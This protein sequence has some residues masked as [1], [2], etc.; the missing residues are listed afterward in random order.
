MAAHAVYPLTRSTTSAVR[1]IV[2]AAGH[3]YGWPV[4]QG[5]SQSISDALASILTAHGGAIE[6]G[7]RVKR[8]ADLPRTD[9]VMLALAPTAVADI[10]GDALPPRVSRAYRRWRY[11]P[12]VFKL[13]LAVEGGLPWTNEY[14]RRAGVVHVGG[15]LEEV[16]AIEREVNRGVMPERPFVLVGQQYLAD[17]TRSSGNIH[18]VWTYA[19]VPNGYP[20]D[21]EEA[22]L[23]QLERFAPGTRERIVGKF[24]RGTSALAAYNTN[25]VGGDILTGANNPRQVLAWPRVALDPYYTG[26]AGTYICSAA[27]PP[28]SGVHGM[29]G[30]NA[31]RSALR[32]LRRS[33]R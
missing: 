32:E 19:H 14:A 11:G 4:A 33:R 5:G 15:T 6:T 8:L 16:V 23:R 26:I 17:P 2:I 18:P 24:A 1:A 9:I 30:Y 12:G 28:G 3:R 25:F 21:A 10:A 31:A 29:C 13:D 7:V 22:I 20:G 27:T